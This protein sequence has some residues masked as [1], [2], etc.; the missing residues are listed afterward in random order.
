MRPRTV[1]WWKELEKECYQQ[2]YV[3][4]AW[5]RRFYFRPTKWDYKTGTWKFDL[6]KLVASVP[7][8]SA[9]EVIYGAMIRARDEGLK[10]RFQAH[11]ELGV[12]MEYEDDGEVLKE[13][14]EY[15]VDKL[16]GWT[17]SADLGVGDNW[18]EAKL[19]G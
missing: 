4:N 19:N 7:Q 11:D 15:E 5:G 16:G 10:L 18:K 9:G 2:G 8:S 14:M 3:S 6:A 13:C 12:S 17:C 1:G